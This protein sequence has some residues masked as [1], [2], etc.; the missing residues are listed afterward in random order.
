[1]ECATAYR[2]QNEC[3]VL[4]RHAVRRTY[5]YV[6]IIE[7]SDTPCPA[8]P[9]VQ[10]TWL[11]D[12]FLLLQVPIGISVERGSRPRT[13]QNAHVRSIATGTEPW[14][15]QGPARLVPTRTIGCRSTTISRSA[16]LDQCSQTLSYPASEVLRKRL[17]VL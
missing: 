12:T 17:D 6:D 9:E 14:F 3:V 15:T 16:E 10:T 4:L 2:G 1:M 7:H 13:R 5:R 8:V 11:T